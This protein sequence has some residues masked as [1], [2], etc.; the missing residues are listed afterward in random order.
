MVW[1]KEVTLKKDK[2]TGKWHREVKLYKAKPSEV[3]SFRVKRKK[4]SKSKGKTC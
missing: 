3:T 1:R 4:K 2:K